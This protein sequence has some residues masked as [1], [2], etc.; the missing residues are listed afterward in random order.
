MKILYEPCAKFKIQNVINILVEV[1][2]SI[3][4]I[5]KKNLYGYQIL[6]GEE[7]ENVRDVSIKTK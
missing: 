5:G 1:I 2:Y 6:E 4:N 3:N 7:N